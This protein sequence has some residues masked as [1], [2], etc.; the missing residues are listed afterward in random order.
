MRCLYRLIGVF[1]LSLPAWAGCCGHGPSDSKLVAIL[2]G[3]LIAFLGIG[4]LLGA[5]LGEV[6]LLCNGQRFSFKRLLWSTAC[7]AVITG[8]CGFL[9]AALVG[10]LGL[11]APVLGGIASLYKTSELAQRIAVAEADDI[12]FSQA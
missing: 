6:L 1:L 2:A 11:V 12:G 7:G 8:C 3:M 9:L 5:G 4:P 10:P